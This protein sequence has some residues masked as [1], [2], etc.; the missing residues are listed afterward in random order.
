[1]KFRSHTKDKDLVVVEV[2]ADINTATAGGVVTELERA[3]DGGAR[4]LILDCTKLNDVASSGMGVLL[5]LQQKVSR[6]GGEMKLAGVKPAVAKMLKLVR[7]DGLFSSYPSL[8]H[9]A[10][11]FGAK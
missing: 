8:E 1:M 5:R 2:D 11:A 9:A 3:I 10:G 4:K 7:I 6:Q